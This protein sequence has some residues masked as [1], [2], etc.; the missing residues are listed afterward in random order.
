M[1]SRSTFAT[2]FRITGRDGT[3]R[4]TIKAGR[5]RLDGYHALWYSRSRTDTSDYDR[6]ARQRCVM[7][8]MLHQ[9]DPTTV[10]LKFRGI[11]EAGQQVVSTDIPLSELDTFA[12]LALK[13]KRQ[14]I[15]SVQFVPPL[16]KTARPDFALIKE[17]VREA[18]DAS[19]AP[20]TVRVSSTKSAKATGGTSGAGRPAS[21]SPSQTPDPEDD[22]VHELAQVCAP[23]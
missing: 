6:M 5:Q 1:V 11:A 7:S 23:A 12:D 15:T 18:I 10:L 9:L 13:A 20:A 3:L 4:G 2:T 8:A 22:A 14:K 19:K 17:K 21:P 16:I